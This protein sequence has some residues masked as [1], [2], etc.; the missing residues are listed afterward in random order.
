MNFELGDLILHYLRKLEIEYIFGV[1]GGAIEPLYNALARQQLR[2]EF[3]G[4]GLIKHVLARHESGAAFMADGYFRVSNKLGVC[5]ATSGPGATNMLTGVA[6][7]YAQNIPLLI[8]TGQP[9]IERFGMDA[10]QESSCTG[11][12]TV[13]MF[14][15]CTKFNTLISHPSQLEPKLL[16]AIRSALS[17]TT[18]PAHLSIPVDILRQPTALPEY[19]AMLL[20]QRSMQFLSET[21]IA[22]LLGNMNPRHRVSVLVGE[23]CRGHMASLLELAE[24]YHWL[25]VTT[26]MAKG[27]VNENHPLY[28][29]V[30]G[31]AGHESARS[32][33][34][35]AAADRI[36]VLGTLLNEVST[37]GW[38][39]QVFNPERLV[40]ISSNGDQLNSH[41]QA[42]YML[43][44]DI[45]IVIKC[46]MEH[47]EKQS[48]E[49]LTSE[50]NAKINAHRKEPSEINFPESDFALK[51]TNCSYHQK[52]HPRFLIEL[53][54]KISPDSCRVLFDAGNSYL[55]GIH[56]WLCNKTG[57]QDEWRF[58]TSMGFSTMG[59]A[60]GAAVGVAL[61]DPENWVVC[62]TGD[63]S[64]LMNGQEISTAA[65]LN[66]KILYVILNDSS[67][68]TVK[69]GQR[70][71]GAENIANRLPQVNFAALAEAMGVEAYRIASESE[72]LN[73]Q[74]ISPFT[75]AGPVLLDICID[76]EA[77]PPMGQRVRVLNSLTTMETDP[78]I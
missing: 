23:G 68:G 11:V 40:F 37:V 47:F 45:P 9:T 63:G 46:L 34:L 10:L 14:E 12:D 19:N 72:L 29:G 70:L 1:P 77:A 56:Y 13:K 57:W 15:P 71:A 51:E 54:N 55:W 4:G 66:L 35:P 41:V 24:R 32:A 67:L 48:S 20:P 6:N 17:D 44:A 49:T 75:G 26:P 27:L 8:I 78:C 76:P 16:K 5:C 28:C 39:Q 22:E 31:M 42:R 69:H 60:I 52:I 59:W 73:L 7:A 2:S 3:L 30:F 62:V 58:H 43:S 18:G 38:D 36:L 33:L 64:L 61:A 25:L 21:S 53:L 65:E 74:T 50:N